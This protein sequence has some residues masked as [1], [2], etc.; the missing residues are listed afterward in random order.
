MFHDFIET[1]MQLYIDDVIIKSSSKDGH[2]DHLRQ[3]FERMR[4]HGLKMNPLKCA[5]YVHAGDF[6]GFV[7]H[8]RGIVINLNKTEAIQKWEVSYQ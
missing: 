3:L 5:F 7:F 2:L 8:K 4:K 6:F 1:F